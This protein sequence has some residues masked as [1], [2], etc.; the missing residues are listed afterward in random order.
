MP[1]KNQKSVPKIPKTRGKRI[2]LIKASVPEKKKSEIEYICEIY[3]S[4][5]ISKEKQ[6]YCLYLNTTRQFSSLNYEI[7]VSVIK[8]KNSIDIIILGLKTKPAY[9]SNSGPAECEILFEDLYGQHVVNIVKQ[10]GSINSALIDFNVFKKQIELVKVFLPEKKNNRE[11][12]NFK[13]PVDKFIYSTK[14]GNNVS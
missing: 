7:S 6:Y 11:F 10:D 1:L 8:Q 4:T 9:I 12:I 2:S 14:G 3:F 5:D 13:V